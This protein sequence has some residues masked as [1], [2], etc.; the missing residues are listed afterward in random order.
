MNVAYQTLGHYQILDMI[1]KGGMGVV[2]RAKH[3]SLKRM[4]ALKLLPP[5]RLKG[6][7]G[8]LRF[9][10][11]IE[12]L[13]RMNHPNIAT[14]YDSGTSGELHYLAME[15][16]EGQSLRTL[17][18]S[19][20]PLPIEE[21]LNYV[22]QAAQGLAYAHREGVIHRDIKPSNLMLT[23]DGIVKILDL[24]VAR[25]IHSQNVTADNS[26]IRDLTSQMT[27]VGTAEYCSPEQA[28][29]SSSVSTRSDVYSLG[30][31]LYFLLTGKPVFHGKS[32]MEYLMSHQS[33][34]RPSVR[35]QNREIPRSVDRMLTKM[36]AIAPEN[37]FA[38]MEEL[39]EAIDGLSLEPR[40]RVSGV[41]LGIGLALLAVVALSIFAWGNY[42]EVDQAEPPILKTRFVDNSPD[43]YDDLMFG[44]EVKQELPAEYE[45]YLWINLA[46]ITQDGRHAVIAGGRFD[47]GVETRY[48]VTIR[49]LA[50]WTIAG[51]LTTPRSWTWC[52]GESPDGKQLLVGTGGSPELSGGKQLGGDDFAVY[53]VRL[54]AP[55]S[56]PVRF[57]LHN[58]AISGAAFLT[59][60]R[61]VSGSF[62]E[63]L[64][65]F[66]AVDAE[67]LREYENP[68]GEILAL[69]AS[70]DRKRFAT[71][72][73]DSV[74]IWDP[75]S[76]TH[77]INFA[78]PL[79]KAVAFSG[80]NS[81]LAVGGNGGSI[82]VWDIQQR[83]I[84]QEVEHLSERVNCIVWCHRGHAILTGHN[85]GTLNLWDLRTNELM[86]RET[87]EE[88]PIKCLS[89]SPDSTT[90]ISGSSD[91]VVRLWKLSAER[92]RTNVR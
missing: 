7:L 15:L 21:A 68:F 84:V 71:G 74:A 44:L 54:N 80:D 70:P 79:A 55:N 60:D 72:H 46:Q 3:V 27:F 52:G 25:I 90:A 2:Y 31:T 9:Q 85:D 16:I 32:T 26:T 29:D 42:Q 13:A 89:V 34:P 19:R 61:V 77:L 1:D 41:T 47:N 53:V 65:L 66:D 14:A 35:T 30:C 22:R 36:L 37:R 39:I 57:G 63:T 87:I 83:R 91:G 28:T 62:D 75:E 64:R 69:A 76:G 82:V 18:S 20:G 92:K 10:R 51:E 81:R 49:N 88:T 59:G 56:T 8:L 78:F 48:P 45:K 24:G 38:S 12:I 43:R 23:N 5:S 50:D 6:K 73:F 17:V 58:K 33:M 4:V 40:P 86:R 67:Q 11:E